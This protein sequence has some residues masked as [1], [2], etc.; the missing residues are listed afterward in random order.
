MITRWERNNLFVAHTK[1]HGPQPEP[2][3]IENLMRTC[4]E[5]AEA[6]LDAWDTNDIS[7]ISTAIERCNARLDDV[8]GSWPSMK[9]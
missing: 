9:W 8:R 7:Q 2:G 1:E 4:H 5:V 3:S 6:L